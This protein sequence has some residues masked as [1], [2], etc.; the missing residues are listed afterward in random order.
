ME[1]L[2]PL[3]TLLDDSG[4]AAVP[5]LPR[6]ETLFGGPLR[7]PP[8][9]DRPYVISNFVA[10]IDGVVSLNEP[11]IA[12][13]VQIS[14]LNPHDLFVMALLRAVS[15]AVIAGSSALRAP[16]G[17]IWTAEFIYP[18]LAEAFSRLREQLGKPPYPLNVI[19]TGA[20]HIDLS[21]PLFQD[22]RNSVLVITTDAGLERLSSHPPVPA[23]VQIVSKKN[24]GVIGAQVLMDAVVP[25]VGN[26]MVLLEG[27]PHMLGEFLASHLVDELFLTVAPQIAGRDALIERPGL[28][29]GKRFAPVSPLW[30]RL[31]G[32]KRAG[33]YLFLRYRFEGAAQPAHQL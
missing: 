7:F 20:G 32:V 24:A 21:L 12:G 14:G 6:L 15:D 13:G 30:E 29:E 1:V 4:G 23:S 26:G 17:H 18:P 19:V 2:S 25:L 11:G 8:H 16:P 33:D 5:L 27:G 9:P 22:G 28:V 31:T 10:T 3:Q